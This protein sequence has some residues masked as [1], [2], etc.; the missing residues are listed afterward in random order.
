MNLTT[1]AP[2]TGTEIT[3]D[4]AVD[5][6]TL[7]WEQGGYNFTLTFKRWGDAE[8]RRLCGEG[9]WELTGEG[10]DYELTTI[11][12]DL[13]PEAALKVAVQWIANCV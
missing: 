2:W 10:W 12:D 9:I 8:M 5:G 4:A 3:V 1:N 7:K 13:E 6:D 11:Y